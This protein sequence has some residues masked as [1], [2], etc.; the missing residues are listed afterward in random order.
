MNYNKMEKKTFSEWCNKME[1]KTFSEWCNAGQSI[2][3]VDEIKSKYNDFIDESIK[4][5]ENKKSASYKSYPAFSEASLSS[6]M[7]NNIER[8]DKEIK[9]LKDK[10]I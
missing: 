3:E 6:F 1:K 5:L 10:K 7:S 4:K 8:W 9:E 2:N